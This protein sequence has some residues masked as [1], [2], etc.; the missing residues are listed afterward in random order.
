MEAHGGLIDFD[1]LTVASGIVKADSGGQVVVTGT[2]TLS[3]VEMQ[4]NSGGELALD[5]AVAGSAGIIYANSG[6][7]VYVAS[8]ASGSWSSSSRVAAWF[9]AGPTLP[10]KSPKPATDYSAPTWP[11]E[12]GA[13]IRLL[14]R[15]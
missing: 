7:T 8:S 11:I 2:T 4:A 14:L 10:E 15:S 6:G 13:V 3:G 1:P 5:G 9:L 12:P